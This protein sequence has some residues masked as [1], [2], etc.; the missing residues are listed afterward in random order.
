MLQPHNQSL[1][2]DQA[3]LLGISMDGLMM[4]TFHRPSLYAFRGAWVYSASVRK[5]LTLPVHDSTLSQQLASAR[6]G[7]IVQCTQSAPWKAIDL[8]IFT[9]SGE[10]LILD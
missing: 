9:L 2:L 10:L 3:Y 8:D 6:F 1:Y 4:R 5:A 7:R